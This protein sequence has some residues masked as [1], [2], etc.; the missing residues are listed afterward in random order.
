MLKKFN[1]NGD[2]EPNQDEQ[3]AVRE[4]MKKSRIKGE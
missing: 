2:V 4:A 3:N 1:K